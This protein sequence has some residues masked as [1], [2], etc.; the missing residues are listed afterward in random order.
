MLKRLFVAINLPKEIKEELGEIEKELSEI[1]AKWVKPENLHLTLVF[2]GYLKK[3]HLEKVF[4][5]I[6]NST[7]GILPFSLKLL[8]TTFAPKKEKI[9]RM[10]WVEVEKKKELL[11][12]QKKLVENLISQ[13]VPFL[14]E[15]REFS[16][17]ITLCRIRKWEFKS[18]DPE[19]VPSAFLE[20]NLEFQ[21]KSVDLMESKLKREGPDYFLVKSFPLKNQ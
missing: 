19:L 7:K 11:D 18:L 6:E 16:P 15:E 12:L 17:H 20:V 13:N 9:P 10:V 3:E 1:P 2:L 8:N 4:F 5:A 21:V 14:K